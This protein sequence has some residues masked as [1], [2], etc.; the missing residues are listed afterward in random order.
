M[1]MTLRGSSCGCA[2]QTAVVCEQLSL[3]QAGAAAAHL[4]AVLGGVRSVD[5]LQEG[6]V[7]AS[8]LCWLV[9]RAASRNLSSDQ[10]AAATARAR[11]KQPK[12]L[13]AMGRDPGQHCQLLGSFL[14]TSGWN[15]V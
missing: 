4:L 8:Q 14:L 10:Y 12:Q 5:V 7:Q 1:V 2:P 13:R 9:N 11:G 3:G 15:T 6:A